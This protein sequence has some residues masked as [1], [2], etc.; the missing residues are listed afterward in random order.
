MELWII[1]MLALPS[2]PFIAIFDYLVF[3]RFAKCP[4]CEDKLEI[5]WYYYM[6]PTFIEFVIFMAGIA[7]GLSYTLQLNA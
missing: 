1:L 2:I 5:K 4:R 7:I 3:S 6:I